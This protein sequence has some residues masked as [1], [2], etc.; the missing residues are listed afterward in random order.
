MQFSSLKI[1]LLHPTQPVFL[2]VTETRIPH[3]HTPHSSPS[4]W[5]ISHAQSCRTP[6]WPAEQPLVL[7][8]VLGAHVC[9][10]VTALPFCFCMQQLMQVG[11][12]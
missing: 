10:C 7:C 11:D 2:S 5:R 9:A 6:S 3:A 12:G 4:C 8:F 1:D